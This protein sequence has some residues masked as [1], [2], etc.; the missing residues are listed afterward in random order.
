[1]KFPFS[2]P[3]SC[4]RTSE[5]G[6]ESALE[7]RL[8]EVLDAQ[9]ALRETVDKAMV[10]IFIVL[11]RVVFWLCGTRS[12]CFARLRVTFHVTGHSEWSLQS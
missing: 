11:K 4:S 5:T 10:S 1:M 3:T 9:S 2:G 12:L 8:K 6:S 7:A